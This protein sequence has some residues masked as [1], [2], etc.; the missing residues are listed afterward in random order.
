MLSGSGSGKAAPNERKAVLEETLQMTRQ[1]EKAKQAFSAVCPTICAPSQ[2]DPRFLRLAQRHLGNPAK[3]SGYLDKIGSSGKYLLGLIN[4]ILEM[5]RMEHGQV[6]LDYQRFDL[7]ACVEECLSTFRIQAEREN[8]KLLERFN[9]QSAAVLGDD[10]RIQQVLNNLLSNAFK[11][12]PEQ[13]EISLSVEQLDEGEYTHYK[14]VVTDTGIGMSPDFLKR[15]SSPM[16]G[17]MRFSNRQASGTGLGMSIT[18][19]LVTQMGGEIRVESTPGSGSAFTVILP[20]APAGEV[21]EE[22]ETTAARELFSL[23]GRQILTGGG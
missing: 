8:K 13:G 18:K 14:F 21:L 15:F 12:T 9:V 6:S 3:L 22:R 11:F 19:N 2:R 17:E 20:L 5:A 16:P 7:R 1:D 10:F 23:K 4:D